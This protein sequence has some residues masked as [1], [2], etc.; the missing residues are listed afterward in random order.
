MTKNLH[1][2]PLST[3][4]LAKV[5]WDYHHT[6]HQLEHAECILVLG[7]NDTRVAERGA[8]LFLKGYAPL[9]VFSGGLGNFTQGLWSEPE[10]DKFAKIAFRMGVPKENVLIE[11]K[12]TNTGENIRNTQRLLAEKGLNPQRFIVVQKPF[13]ERRSLATFLVHWPE[14]ELMVTSPQIPMEDYPNDEISPELLINAMVGDLQRIKIYPKKGFQVY[15]EIPPAVWAAYVK[16]VG[17]GYDK[18]LAVE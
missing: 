6:H 14:K 13:M 18:H 15:Q 2:I 3:W 5:L 17:L 7:S 11:N 10:A 12:S 16:L 9:L 8:E 4:S 1:G